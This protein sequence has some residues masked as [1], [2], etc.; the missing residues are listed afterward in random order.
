MPEAMAYEEAGCVPLPHS[1]HSCAVVVLFHPDEGFASRLEKLREQFVQIVLVDNSPAGTLLGTVPD[2]VAILRNGE[3]LGIAKA[4]N[5]GVAFAIDNGFAWVAT[6]DQD[7]DLLPGYL[8]E[9][10]AIAARQAPEVAL[11][12]CNYLRGDA[13]EAVHAAPAGAG[14]A[15]PRATLITSGTFMPARFVRDI[16]GFRE[17]FFIDS[18]DHE[19]CLRAR[20]HGAKVM[21][22]VRPFMH[23]AMGL[24]A[25]GV[26]RPLSLQHSPQRRYYI[27]RNTLL[28]I[29]AHGIRN[30]L[31]AM[32]QLARLMGE[33]TAILAFESGKFP[34][35]RAS[36]L[37]LWHGLI[38]RSG[39]HDIA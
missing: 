25:V 38:G 6:F 31:W 29:R 34:K 36:A 3:N 30:P 26:G 9:V 2:S 28:T 16:G 39:R 17:D 23:H 12:G 8:D 10:V 13:S 37:G 22:A 24:A 14:D 4:L 15:L 21:M 33:W 27:M 7:S 1:S 11:V 35:L 19:F 5:Q 32:R 20:D 18:V